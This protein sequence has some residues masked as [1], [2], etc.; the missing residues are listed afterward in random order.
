MDYKGRR[1]K[2]GIFLPAKT[3]V[4]TLWYR[5]AY[6]MGN[7]RREKLVS[8]SANSKERGGTGYPGREVSG[9]HMGVLR[10]RKH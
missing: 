5:H 6:Q 3:S 1:K 2:T 4:T 10:E 8:T 9:R 7:T